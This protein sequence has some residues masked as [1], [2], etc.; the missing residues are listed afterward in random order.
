MRTRR[1]YRAAALPFCAALCLLLCS[2]SLADQLRAT[3]APLS[4]TKGIDGADDLVYTDTDAAGD[5]VPSDYTPVTS[6]YAYLCLSDD[7]KALYDALS[8]N[9]DSISDEADE[10]GYPI[11]Q[12]ILDGCLL[13]SAEIAVAVRAVCDDNPGVFWTAQAYTWITDK[14][15]DYTAVQLYSVYP[16]DE[17]IAMKAELDEVLSDFYASVPKGLSLYERERFAHDYLIDSCDYD[18]DNLDVTDLDAETLKAHSV[19]GALVEKLCVCEGYGTAMQLLLNSLGVECVTLTGEAYNSSVKESEEQRILHLWNAVKL[20]DGCWYHVDATWDDQ[21]NAVQ[22]YEYFNLSDEM[23]FTDHTLS[24]THDSLSE[25]EIEETGAMELNFFVPSCSAT[26][27]NFYVWEFS[28][29]TDYEPTMLDDSLCAAAENREAFYT[30]YIEP[31]LDYDE[32]VAKLFRD[33]PQSFFD[34]IDR[35][36][37]RLDSVEI[38]SSNLTYYLNKPRRSIVVELQYY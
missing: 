3:F 15:A 23:I 18:S 26:T 38:D 25:S 6:R 7:E 10:Y 34:V 20:D 27:Y 8:E 16:P 14:D 11:S 28:H 2:C 5:L 1:F 37:R 4:N 19:Y 36:N 24:K 12:V 32:A 17:V 35:V 13:S 33:Y 31:T 22:R 9:I 29:L 21:E 30:F